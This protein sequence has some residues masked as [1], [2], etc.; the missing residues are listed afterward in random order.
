[1]AKAYLVAFVINIYALDMLI[2]CASEGQRLRRSA[3]ASLSVPP[4]NSR[5]VSPLVEP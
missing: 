4:L 3:N 1:M 2:T 5:T